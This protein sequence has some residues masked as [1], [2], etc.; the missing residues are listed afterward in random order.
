MRRWTGPI[1]SRCCFP[2]SQ[3]RA[4][5][6]PWRVREGFRVELVAEGFTLPVLVAPVPSPSDAPDAPVAYVTELAGAV[7]ALG[8]DGSVWAYATNILSE[9]PSA[10]ITE[11]AGE[12]GTVGIAVDP[13]TGDVYVTTTYRDG[14][15]LYN[16]IVRLES[17]DGGRTAARAVDVLRMEG[18]A[19]IPSHQIQGLLFGH[20]DQLYVAVGNGGFQSSRGLDDAFF[21]G[22]VLRLNRDGSAPADNP[23][24]DPGQPEAPISYQWAKG[25]R[26]AV[27]IAQ[28][29]GDNAVYTADNGD[30]IDRLLRMEAG[31]NYGYAGTDTSLLQRGL[32]F[33]SPGIAPVG[34]AF[35]SGGAFPADRQGNLYVGAFGPAPPSFVRGTVDHG[36]EIWEIEL[37][38]AGAVVGRPMTFVR[39]VG[40]GLASVTGVAYLAEGL[41]FLEFA[42][43][44]PQSANPEPTGRLWRVAPDAG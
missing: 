37:D 23:H 41:Y 8:R 19:T 16:K 27:A 29:P 20:D 43:D 33:F 7:K 21:G 15:D 32:W 18:E 30:F 22:K 11:L 14:E 9:Q 10:P 5:L 25:L 35:A 3:A 4:P 42:A 2:H 28:R 24:F 17:D 6:V 40:D 39:Y 34:V 12:T 13:Q 26:N 38:D 1:P 31:K 36:K 44:I